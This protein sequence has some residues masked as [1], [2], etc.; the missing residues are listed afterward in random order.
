MNRAYSRLEVK[1]FSEDSR[2]FEGLASTPTPDRVGD[3]V[4]PMGAKFH[5]P[6]P[7]LWQHKSDQPIG[8]VYY[9]RPTKDRIEIRGRVFEAKQ[10]RTL[11]DRLDEAWESLKLGLVKGLSIGF[12][13]ISG[14]PIKGKGFRFKEWDWHEL[15]TVTIPCNTEATISAIKSMDRELLAASGRKKGVVWL[16]EKDW[17]VSRKPGVVYINPNAIREE[18]T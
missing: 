2:E 8:E 15:S 11:K 6:I 9:A 5:L 10:S 13:P 18:T 17:R 7:L 1:A 4:E 12:S 16:E 14:E 3:I